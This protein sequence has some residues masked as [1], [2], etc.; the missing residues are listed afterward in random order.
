MPSDSTRVQFILSRD[1]VDALLRG[2]QVLD[3]G[4]EFG[5]FEVADER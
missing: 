2:E 1:N 3:V 5:A 4:L